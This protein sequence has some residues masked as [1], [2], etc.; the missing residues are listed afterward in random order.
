[1]GPGTM[2]GEQ[3]RNLCVSLKIHNGVS[4]G[5]GLIS[6]ELTF[7]ARNTKQKHLLVI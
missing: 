3:R 1:M 6:I 4:T 2:T 7:L 5:I